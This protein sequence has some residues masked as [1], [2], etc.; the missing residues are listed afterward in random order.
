V[1][2]EVVE[3]RMH[4]WVAEGERRVRFGLGTVGR[5][6]GANLRQLGR[7]AEEVGFDSYWVQDHPMSGPDCWTSLAALAV[8]TERL[9]LGSFVSCVYYRSPVQLARL[10]ADV[11]Q[12]SGG[13]LVLGLGNGDDPAEFAQ[14]GLPFPPV[15]ARQAALE[16][17]VRVV[18]ALWSGQPVTHRSEL[19]DLEGARVAAGPIQQP[20]V[21]VLIGGGGERVTLRQVAQYA[22][23]ANIGESE[24]IGGARTTEDVRRKLAALR[25]HCERLGR[26]YD[27]VLRSHV[28]LP[29]IAAE[30][31]AA[32]AAKVDERFGSLSPEQQA[33]RR[34]AVA[35]GTPAQ[36]V[37]YY[38]GLVDAGLRYFVVAIDAD[39][40]ES[41]DLLARRV[42]PEVTSG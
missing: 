33:R 12:L 9:R 26:P 1:A 6:T 19:G 36:L 11:D 23:M 31:P 2:R 7:W 29:L 22:D 5:R 30:T 28:A 17:T 10:A 16:E 34:A 42:I 3:R 40:E 35:A 39:D 8:A 24:A 25:G 4:P 37:D 32:V 20:H 18:Q 27:A 15:P 38:R 13:R 41:R 14:M 21:P